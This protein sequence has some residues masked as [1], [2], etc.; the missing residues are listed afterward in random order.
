MMRSALLLGATGLVGGHCLDLLLADSAITRVVT[1]GRRPSG[2]SHAKLDERVGSMDRMADHADAFAVSDVFCCV[3]TTIRVAGSR[4]A[5]R[6]VDHDIAARAAEMA[7]ER[8]AR[9]FLLVSSMGADPGSRIFYNRVKGETEADV[10][11]LPFAGVALLRPS[12]L[13]GQRAEARTGEAV[14]QRVFP[15]LSPF[16]RGP[17]R[18]YRAVEARTVAAAMLRLASE[19]VRG[20]RIVESDEI[21]RLGR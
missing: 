8:G 18:K 7:S 12:L 2:R 10:A 16:M 21:E 5:F 17:L 20:V 14:A 6:R 1:L 9:H 4:E 11:A 13:L 15:L 19:G 3:G